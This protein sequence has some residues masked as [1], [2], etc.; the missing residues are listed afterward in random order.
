MGKP[1]ILL[2]HYPLI[3]ITHAVRAVVGQRPRRS[4]QA[5]ARCLP[6]DPG[7][8]RSIVR[9]YSGT[10]TTQCARTIPSLGRAVPRQRPKNSRRIS[11]TTVAARPLDIHAGLAAFRQWPSHGLAA[12]TT[13]PRAWP[14][15]VRDRAIAASCPSSIRQSATE[16][17][18]RG[19]PTIPPKPNECPRDIHARYQKNSQR[20]PRSC[21]GN[22]QFTFS[23]ESA[24]RRRNV[25]RV[26]A[27]V[28]TA[29]A[30]QPRVY[31]W[32]AQNPAESPSRPMIVR[33]NPT[34]RCVNSS[35]VP[36]GC[37]CTACSRRQGRPLRF[38]YLRKVAPPVTA[39]A[40]PERLAFKR[41][42]RNLLRRKRTKASHTE[43]IDYL[44]ACSQTE[45]F[46][47]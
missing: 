4:H 22:G 5:S 39:L 45:P 42:A 43:C 26:S 20:C 6:S 32:R 47:V 17:S 14:C 41:H 30:V 9:S 12:S 31:T 38:G 28:H 36:F 3:C 13:W 10:S 11:G 25:L 35:S 19:Q 40:A 29:S 8:V 33:T 24:T 21:P 37:D 46:Q 15:H 34:A 18:T 23:Q 44:G 1:V 16:L 2:R 27:E 7:T